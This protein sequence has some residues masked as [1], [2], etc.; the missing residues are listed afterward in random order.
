SRRAYSTCLASCARFQLLYRGFLPNYLFAPDDEVVAIGQDGLV[1][2]T[3][4][5]LDG[6]PLIGVNP[7]R[8][9]YDGV[10]L[11]FKPT[12]VA[13]ILPEVMDDRRDAKRVTMARG[14]LSD[15]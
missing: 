4:E 3:L 14:T 1:A 8:L 7:D 12:D 11:P 13:E 6:Q 5:Y 2:N 10:L 9:R 15:G